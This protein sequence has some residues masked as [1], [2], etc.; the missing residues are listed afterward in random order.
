[1]ENRLLVEARS[2]VGSLLI[3]LFLCAACD[4]G[5]GIHRQAGSTYALRTGRLVMNLA[6]QPQTPDQGL[7]ED[8]PDFTF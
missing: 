6:K 3:A 4:S 5:A 8:A 7:G 1:M 2:V